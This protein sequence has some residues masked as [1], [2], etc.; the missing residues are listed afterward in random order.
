MRVTNRLSSKYPS[1]KFAAVEVL[2]LPNDTTNK[3]IEFRKN[4]LQKEIKLR[5]LS[6]IKHIEEYNKFFKKFN[7][8]VPLEFQLKSIINGNSE[9]DGK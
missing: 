8:K 6:G 3:K 9:Q 2:N 7:K 4:E 1:I 5:N